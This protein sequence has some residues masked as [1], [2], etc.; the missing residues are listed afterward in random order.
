MLP[1]LK[2]GAYSDGS[3]N[4]DEGARLEAL[5]GRVV[6]IKIKDTTLGAV[7]CFRG[8]KRLQNGRSAKT[9]SPQSTVFEVRAATYEYTRVSGST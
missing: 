9:T 6:H 1:A 5:H 8:S 3:R 4:L 7:S 2:G